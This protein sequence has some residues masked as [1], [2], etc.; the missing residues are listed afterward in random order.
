MRG[1][2]CY[3][4]ETSLLGFLEGTGTER[5]EKW[6]RLLDIA[7]NFGSE[8]YRFCAVSTASHF[9]RWL[10]GQEL[11]EIRIRAIAIKLHP[12]PKNLICYA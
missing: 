7:K 2:N 9:F 12:V 1:L 11:L 4:Q 5:I 10:H 8:N 6:V 3:K